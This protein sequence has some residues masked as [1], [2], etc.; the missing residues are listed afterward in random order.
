MTCSLNISLPSDSKKKI[1]Q[2]SSCFCFKIFFST[3]KNKFAEQ[4]IDTTGIE[5]DVNSNIYSLQSLSK[6]S[7][8]H[9]YYDNLNLK[10]EGIVHFTAQVIS[11]WIFQI[12]RNLPSN[13][14]S[15]TTFS[16]VFFIFN[17]LHVTWQKC[18]ALSRISKIHVKQKIFYYC[19]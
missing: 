19:V 17:I 4:F 15:R 11:K 16:R 12:L 1:A 8:I 2:T 9:N 14:Y 10:K 6:M 3:K 5:F 7:I 13:Q 18:H